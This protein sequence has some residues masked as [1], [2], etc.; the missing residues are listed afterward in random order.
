MEEGK[1][2][3][4]MWRISLLPFPRFRAFLP[5]TPS[6]PIFAPASQATVPQVGP[7]L[8]NSIPPCLT[9]PLSFFSGAFVNSLYQQPTTEQEILLKFVL[10]FVQELLHAMTKLR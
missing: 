8:A 6:P 4:G 9:S 2:G 7:N 10:V 3:R 1:K 5:P